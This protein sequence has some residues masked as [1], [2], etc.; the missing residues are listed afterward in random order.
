L[1]F[2]S[3][4]VKTGGFFCEGDEPEDMMRTCFDT[5]PAILPSGPCP[6]CLRML[7]LDDSKLLPEPEIGLEIAP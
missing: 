2:I 5:R 7:R 1:R 4:P 6:E 3:P